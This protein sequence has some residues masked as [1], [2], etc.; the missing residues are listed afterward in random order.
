[1]QKITPCLWFDDQA[2]EAAN[3]YVSLFKNSK[4]LN[5]SYY[6]EGAPKPAGSVLTVDFV[7]D[8]VE[9]Q[10]LNGGPEFRFTEAVSLSVKTGSQEETD[11]LWDGLIAGGGEPSQCGWLK[12]KFGL[13]WQIVPTALIN[14]LSDPDQ[15]KSNRV[16]QAMLTMGKIDIASLQ[17][18]YDGE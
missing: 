14:L 3:L 4:I 8:G 17:R 16:M 6:G 2:E 5:T 15:E 10:A 11:E 18:A 7:L 12:D 13:S 1:M 9:L